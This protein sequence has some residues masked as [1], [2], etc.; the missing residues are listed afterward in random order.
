MARQTQ[1]MNSK[2]SLASLGTQLKKEIRLIKTNANELAKK[3]AFQVMKD[4]TE[5]TVVDTSKAVSN[6]VAT[7]DKPSESEIEANVQGKYGS[8]EG[9]SIEIAILKSNSAITDKKPG[10]PIFIVNNIEGNKYQER[11][12]VLE[13]ESEAY[14]NA[15]TAV[16]KANLLLGD[17]K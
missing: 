14:D 10:H 1:V 12:R 8:T 7:L 11:A 9:Q 17:N 13:A 16:A 6:W 5:G 15:I 3:I 2:N 4:V